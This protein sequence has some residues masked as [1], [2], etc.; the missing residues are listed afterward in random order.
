MNPSGC[1]HS[2]SHLPIFCLFNHS[3]P[4]LTPFAVQSAAAYIFITACALL[5]VSG[6]IPVFL[7]SSAYRPGL[8]FKEL[9]TI[10]KPFTGTETV[11]LH[12]AAAV[13]AAAIATAS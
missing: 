5:A 1:S 2:Y 13:A 7:R 9:K 12:I 6:S 3:I 11:A 8:F 10:S 4:N